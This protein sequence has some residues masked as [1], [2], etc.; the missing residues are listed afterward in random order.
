[1]VEAQA[2]PAHTTN[3]QAELIAFTSAFPLPQGQSLN[4]YTDSKYAFHILLS[5][6]AIWKE[7]RLF[8]TK[9]GSI[10]NASQIMA[11]LEASCLP[12]ATGIIHC[13]SHPTDDSIVSKGNNRA[14]EAARAAALR[15]LDLSYPPQD[16]L[17]LQS[18]SPPSPID[19]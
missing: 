16:I 7:H 9:G 12:T 10:T 8:T 17:T 11:M 3:Q 5:H 2:F 1:M 6:A 4:I 19:I 13:R 15:G 14:N 18:T